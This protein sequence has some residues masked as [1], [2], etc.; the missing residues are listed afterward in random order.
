MDKWFS[1]SNDGN[2]NSGTYPRPVPVARAAASFVSAS[3]K[4][5]LINACNDTRFS[6]FPR[7]HTVYPTSFERRQSVA[8]GVT[9]DNYVFNGKRLEPKSLLAD[10][11]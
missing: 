4:R 6:R 2:V 5:A 9:P 8:K 10:V 11:G 1:A 7:G 3:S